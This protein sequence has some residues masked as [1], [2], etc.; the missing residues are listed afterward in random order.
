MK[1]LR[2]MKMSQGELTVLILAK[3]GILSNVVN[4]LII[5]N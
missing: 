4:I 3:L 5:I 1:T 2:D